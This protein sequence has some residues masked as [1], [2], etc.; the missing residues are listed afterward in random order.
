LRRSPKNR[1]LP[2]LCNSSRAAASVSSKL[3]RCG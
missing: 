1:S 3:H 2:Q